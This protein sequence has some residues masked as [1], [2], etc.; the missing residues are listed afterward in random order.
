M[1]LLKIRGLHELVNQNWRFDYQNFSEKKPLPE[2]IKKYR[3]IW[4]NKVDFAIGIS[5]CSKV[6]KLLW[7]NSL[8][9]IIYD[10]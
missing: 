9:M 10:W 7:K 5:D 8:L 1:Y 6:L 3:T 2:S 4:K